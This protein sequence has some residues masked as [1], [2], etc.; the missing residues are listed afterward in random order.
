LT[1]ADVTHPTVGPDDPPVSI[2]VGRNP[3]IKS[4][5]IAN[6]RVWSPFTER[7]PEEVLELLKHFL[8]DIGESCRLEGIKLDL[9]ISVRDG[10]IDWSPLEGIDRILAGMKSLG[11]VYIELFNSGLSS[12]NW[13][14]EMRENVARRFP[15]LRAGGVLVDVD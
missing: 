6:I 4:L 1:S 14:P 11:K 13:Y 5:H 2:N 3:N 15:L 9:Q 10:P 8:S 7:S 12:P